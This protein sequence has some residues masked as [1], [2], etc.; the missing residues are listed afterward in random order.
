MLRVSRRMLWM[1]SAAFPLHN[2]TRVEAFKLK[3]DRGAALLRFLKWLIGLA[4]L[5]AAINFVNGE[6]TSVGESGSPLFI[7]VLIG[8]AVFLLK[9]LFE[10]AKPVLA[11]ETASGSAVIVTLPNMEELRQIAGRIA[12]AIDNPDT[13][14]TTVVN[15]FNNTHHNGP[16][17]NMHGGQGN[18][19]I[20]L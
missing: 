18:T 20:R 3:P 1:G 19:G 10:P 17:V 5:F 6:D 12:Y 4:L 13:E 9:E 8:L 11:V 14:F 2:I 7:V 15:Q 16:V